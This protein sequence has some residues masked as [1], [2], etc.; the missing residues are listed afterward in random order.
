MRKYKK[1]DRVVFHKNAEGR[2]IGV[3][4][5]VRDGRLGSGGYDYSVQEDGDDFYW[6]IEPCFVIEHDLSASYT[7]HYQERR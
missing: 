7:S 4:V 6:D 5:E 3:V 2:A 1:G